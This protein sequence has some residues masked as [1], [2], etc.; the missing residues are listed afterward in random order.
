MRPRTKLNLLQ[1]GFA[2]ML[3][4]ALA[5]ASSAQEQDRSKI[6]DQYK[7]DLTKLYSS[8]QAWRDAKNQLAAEL[9]KMAQ[10]KGTLSRSPQ[11]LADALEMES[12]LEKEFYRLS[13]Y[14]GLISDQDTRVSV[15]QGMQ[16]EITQ[17]GAT[18]GADTA[19]IEPE[20]LTIED[21]KLRAF[22]AQEPRLNVYR[23]YLDDVTRRRPHIGTDAEEKLLAASSV[24]S[25]GPS[26]TYNIFSNAD[27]PHPSITL[28]DGKTTKLTSSEYE[29]QRASPNRSDREKVMSTFFKTLGDYRGTF[30]STLDTSIQAS[31]FYAH[32]RH[33]DTSLDAALDGPNIP[34]A[35]YSKLLEGV[36]RNLATFQRYLR[37]RK[38]LLGLQEL[39]YYDLYAPLV[40][41]ADTH[42]TV[43]ESEKYILE[44]LAPLGPEYA[45]AAKR[46]FAE[47]WIDFYPTEGKASGGYM[48][49]NA[50]DV[51]P[52]ILLNY[53]GKYTDMSTIAHELGHSMQSYFSNKAQPYP[54][55]RYPIFVAEVAS[56]FNEA[57]LIEYMLKKIDDPAVKLSLLGNYLE[58]IKGTVFRQTQFAEFELRMHQMAE[59]G[60]PLT[61]D[62]ISKL[63][64]DIVKKYYGQDQGV[65]IVDDYVAYEWAFIPHFYNNFYVYQY[66]TSFTASSALSEK[67]LSGQPGAT[68][69]YLAFISSGGSKYPIELL[70]DAGVDMTTDEP[71]ELTVKKMNRIMDE[72]EKLLAEMKQP[73]PASH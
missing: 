39:H 11:R 71:L 45:A 57:L 18:F 58:N 62:A 4:F 47:R 70:K 59:K 46:A 52:Y 38:R 54:L 12:T 5:I 72:I 53:N 22:L 49:G 43:E 31:I 21:A 15:Y 10:F 2:S 16:Q 61:G 69:H 35:V 41:T 13:T 24:I 44:A 8:D 25:S 1:F 27:F 60:E 3:P 9:P 66:A 51:H 68:E 7:W 6:P 65:C 26:N 17:L 73:S 50:Y 32:A 42:Y 56:T 28:S 30:G 55:A 48:S 34:T 19:F 36:N 63:Y 29:L 20:I 33:Y 40:K 23:H 14:A 37:L 67:V 64:A